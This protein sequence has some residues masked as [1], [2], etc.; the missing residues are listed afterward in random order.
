MCEQH[1]QVINSS[2][3]PSAMPALLVD[4]LVSLPSKP[5]LLIEYVWSEGSGGSQ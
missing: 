4:G 5:V 2:A 1:D 3:D